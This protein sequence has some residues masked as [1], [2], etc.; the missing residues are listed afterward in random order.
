MDQL[1]NGSKLNKLLIRFLNENVDHSDIR[2]AF[3]DCG[4]IMKRQLLSSIKGSIFKDA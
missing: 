4:P 1:K 3:E 2:Y